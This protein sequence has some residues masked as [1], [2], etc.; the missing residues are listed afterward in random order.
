MAMELWTSP[1]PNGW[2]VTIMLEE[3]KE[4]GVALP[5]VKL[6]PIDLFQ[7]QQFSDAF[8]EVSPNQKIPG[9]RDGDKTI[10]E[11][12]AILLYLAEKYPSPLLPTDESRWDAIQWLFWQ[13]AGVGPTF[14]NKLSYT[15]YM[16]DIPMEQKEHPLQRFN[17]EAQRLLRVLNRQLEGRDYICGDGLT[18]ADIAAYPWVRGWKWSKV[19]ITGHANVVAWVDRVRARPAVERGLSYDFAQDEIDSW[20]EET[21]K[22]YASGGASIASNESIASVS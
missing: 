8:T 16:D 13:A 4:A 14:G 3:L 22:R 5:E 12:C 7:R 18:I 1:T 2:K 17:N 19:D 10:M 15:R 20:S 6:V 9:L 21:R 11:S